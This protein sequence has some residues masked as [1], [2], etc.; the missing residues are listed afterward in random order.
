MYI[1][2]DNS[3]IH[4]AG[5]NQVRPIIEPNAQKELYRTY[6]A[7]LLQLV[8]GN[9]QV[10][11]IFFAGSVPPKM[12]HYGIPSAKWEFAHR[13]YHVVLMKEKLILLIM[14]YS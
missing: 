3:N 7:G 1:F 5:L 8:A 2:W 11:D 13:F 6:F 10:D 12:M 4:Y 14:Y 9:R